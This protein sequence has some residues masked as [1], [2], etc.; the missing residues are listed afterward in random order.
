MLEY[1]S[2]ISELRAIQ[3]A[4]VPVIKMRYQG[5]EIDMTFARLNLPDIPEDLESYFQ[6]STSLLQQLYTD[7][8]INTVELG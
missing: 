6:T 8:Y 3:E 1:Q 2:E 7:N 4:F 5:V